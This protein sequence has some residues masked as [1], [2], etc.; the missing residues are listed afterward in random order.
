MAIYER[1]KEYVKGEL[2]I[3]DDDIFQ[4]MLEAW[5]NQ[6]KKTLYRG[7]N[8]KT[9]KDFDVFMENLNANDAYI[10]NSAASFT[11]NFEIA[12]SFSLTSRSYYIDKDTMSDYKDQHTLGEIISGYR[13]V[14]L[15]VTVPKNKVI[16]VQKSG[17]S[18]EHE[19]LFAPREAINVKI[20]EI[21]T[22]YDLIKEGELNIKNEIIKA[23]KKSR[24]TKTYMV[25]NP[26]INYIRINNPEYLTDNIKNIIVENDISL[27]KDFTK[28]NCTKNIKYLI[29]NSYLTAIESEVD[30][31]STSK[32][33]KK[34]ILFYTPNFT[35]YIEKGFLTKSNKILFKQIAKEVLNIAMQ[36]HIENRDNS[37]T[38]LKYNM[39]SHILPFLSAT[40]K[41]L[42]TR[43]INYKVKENYEEINRKITE[44]F[45]KSKNVSKNDL[46][47]MKNFLQ[48]IIESREK[49]K[50]ALN[51][52]MINIS[53]NINKATERRKIKIIGIKKN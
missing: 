27:M 11:E 7:I 44:N 17:F 8:F 25:K 12:K 1:I 34:E 28:N 22:Y 15:E 31:F 26:F 38:I 19:Y 32:E 14:I 49:S 39:I 5:P 2:H 6:E 20:T 30:S 48:G 42:H 13:G 52:K 51:I 10:Q 33:Q 3:Y 16:D 23:I 53:K 24:E 21:K 35:E 45:I 43:M 36:I 50:V 37:D 41:I 47:L 46:N 4:E 40:D 29:K 9:K 18:L